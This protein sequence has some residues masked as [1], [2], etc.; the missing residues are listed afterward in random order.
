MPDEQ[1]YCFLTFDIEEWFQVENLKDAI[2]A[3]EW[4]SFP[5]SVE[6]NVQ[7][8]LD[9]LDSFSIKAT[10]FIL[11]WIAERH[12]QMVKRIHDS[13]HEVASH[14]YN[15]QLTYTLNDKKI[16][17][18]I[19]SARKKLEDLCGASIRGYRAPSFS[20]DDRLVDVLQEA[21]FTYDSSYSPFKLNARYG[22]ITRAMEENGSV[23][24]FDNGL[25]EVPLSMARL[26]KFTFPIAGG[27]YFRLLPLALFRML[28]GHFINK[29]EFYNFYLHPWEFE[30]EQ[31]RIDSIRW[32][33]KIRHYTGLTKTREHLIKFIRFLQRKQCAF[34]T[35]AEYLELNDYTK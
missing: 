1:K 23:L 35:I 4:D 33:Y 13:G 8:I 7:R 12:P 20:I 14:G 3:E 26:G 10:F 29:N 11:G 16:R 21:G 34:I 28:V 15:H 2:S 19:R 30:P 31:P 27:A 9:V 32:D 6:N 22:N 25:L 24:R 18:D 5:S 17:E